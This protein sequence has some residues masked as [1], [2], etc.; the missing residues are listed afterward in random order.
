MK[1]S[2]SRLKYYSTNKEYAKKQNGAKLNG[3]QARIIKRLI[4]FRTM[5]MTE[6]GS[7]F[8]VSRS[9]VSLINL[10]KIWK[11]ELSSPT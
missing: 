7:L 11:G 9:T 10:D 6:I 5:N 4:A 1:M 8:N 2:K 3:F